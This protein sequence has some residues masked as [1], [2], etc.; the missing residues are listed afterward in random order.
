[1]AVADRPR[2]RPAAHVG[3]LERADQRDRDRLGAALAHR[4]ALAEA[5]HAVVRGHDLLHLGV[6]QPGYALH[7]REQ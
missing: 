5:H 7:V 4:P 6:I 2:R 3:G 1:V